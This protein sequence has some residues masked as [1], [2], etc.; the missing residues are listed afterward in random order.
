[1]R[2]RPPAALVGNPACSRHVNFADQRCCLVRAMR[3]CPIAVL[4]ICATVMSSRAEGIHAEITI[5]DQSK[6]GVSGVAVRFID[7]RNVVV[8]AITGEKGQVEFPALAPGRY[9]VTALKDGFVPLQQR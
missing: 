8:S 4:V 3:V 1:M 9:T 7:S 2:R 6:H 5:L